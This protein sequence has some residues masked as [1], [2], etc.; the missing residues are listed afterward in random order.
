MKA[1]KAIRF[2]PALLGLLLLPVTAANAHTVRSRPTCGVVE[3]LDMAS[4]TVQFSPNHG[5]APRELALTSQTKFVDN[6]H[7]A[8]ADELKDGTRAAV[9]YRTPFFGRPFVTKVVW[10]NGS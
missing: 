7:F 1:L 6:W 4:R 9:Y 10:V 3:R 2:G 5:K 8:P